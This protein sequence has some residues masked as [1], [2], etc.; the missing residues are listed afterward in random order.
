MNFKKLLLKIY[1]MVNAQREY[2][3][4][5]GAPAL[6]RLFSRLGHY[7]VVTLV[8]P[9]SLLLLICMRFLRP[10]LLIRLNPLYATRIGHFAGNTELYLC[11]KDA[12]LNTP[13]VRYVDLSYFSGPFVCN[14][15]L[16]R[17][18]KRHLNVWPSWIL[19]PVFILNRFIGGGV[20]HEVPS[21]SNND[22]DTCNLLE[23]SPPHLWVADAELKLGESGLLSLGIPPG[24][25]FVCLVGRDNAYLKSA[26]VPGGNFDY[27]NFRDVD[28]SNFLAAADALAERGYYVLRMGNRVLKTIKS[29]NPKVI[30]YASSD[31]RSDFLDVYIGAKCLFCITVCSGID[32]I[33][34]IFRRPVCYVNMAPVGYLMSFL[35]DSIGI[36]KKHFDISA[37]RF[38]T[39]SEIF[40]RGVGLSLMA[41]EYS[42]NKIHL[43]EN[44]PQEIKDVALEMLER[45]TM[46]WQP[47]DSDEHLQ[48]KFWDIFPVDICSTYN[49]KALHS[50]IN[51]KYGAQYLRENTW[52]LK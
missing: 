23:N 42:K 27:H 8:A 24:A 34:I 15:Q 33:P 2:I 22:R 5:A 20:I 32:M 25:K 46:C 7:L 39:L 4:I 38:L 18:W 40:S 41:D 52:W 44:S 13:N 26:V 16:A 9:I 6:W 3:S 28:I 17:M 12:G 45:L 11:E 21:K 10:L 51:L 50:K 14:A 35:K 36:C 43:V 47:K 1:F 37:Q 48:E 29:D 30:D 31:V 49:G 19:E